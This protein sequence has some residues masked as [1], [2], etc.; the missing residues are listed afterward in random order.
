[1]TLLQQYFPNV[2]PPS[3]SN[4]NGSV[5]KY[6][7][8]LA[9]GLAKPGRPHFH[10]VTCLLERARSH[11][12]LLA[13]AQVLL[14]PICQTVYLL[15]P[16]LMAATWYQKVHCSDN[17]PFSC[18]NSVRYVGDIFTRAFRCFM[19]SCARVDHHVRH[20]ISSG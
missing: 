5:T 6:V 20:G 19:C 10:L 17:L 7:I 2:T 4:D 1:M 18:L 11:A 8:R 14:R 12:G 15:L 9:Y 16:V 13:R 3:Y